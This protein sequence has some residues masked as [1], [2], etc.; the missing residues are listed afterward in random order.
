M[1][2]T[3]H[4]DGSVRKAD[5]V[6]VLSYIENYSKINEWQINMDENDSIMISPHPDCETLVF[7]INDNQRFAGF[8]KT[9]FA[10]LEIHQKIVKLFYEIKPLLKH[11]NI[12]DESGYWFEYS[13]KANG[14]TANELTEFPEISEKDIVN[15][16]LLQVP[17]HASEYDRSF[18]N[19]TPN[20]IRPPFMHIPTV[21]D[22]MG[23]D[24]LN[25]PN[26][27]TAVEMQQLLENVG[28]AGPPEDWEDNVFYFIN[29]A[30]L[31][32]WQR[33]SGM[34]A[35][36]LRRNKCMAFGWALARG[37]HGFCGGF[38]GQTHRRAHL[39]MDNLEQI[40]EE[41]SPV[42]SLQILYSLYDFVGL[43]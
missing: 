29:L 9:G 39:A 30:V 41:A 34:K 13:E 24:L 4:Y 2:V 19:S 28:L 25:G 27:L 26:I 10:P 12:E 21:R 23:Y 1:G 38:L 11:L 3:I 31:W 15:P 36:K 5:V 16:K 40:E 22:R 37:C 17:L 35:T 32:A 8:V 43:R 33:S 42:R 20:Y 14:Y 6:K 7:C 18:W